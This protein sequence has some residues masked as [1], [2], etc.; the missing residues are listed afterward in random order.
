MRLR[1]VLGAEGA[2]VVAEVDAGRGRDVGQP[3]ARCRRGCGEQK[4]SG[5]AAT[6]TFGGSRDA[7]QTVAN[8]VDHQF[9]GVM[10]VR[11]PA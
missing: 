7:H 11:A 3:E 4:G 1:Q 6:E 9:G 2:A 8:G 10:D 5:T